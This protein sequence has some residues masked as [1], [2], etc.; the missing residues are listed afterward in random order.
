MDWD[1]INR[2]ACIFANAYYSR[3]QNKPVKYTDERKACSS[4]YQSS[5]S[6]KAN[7]FCSLFSSTQIRILR[8]KGEDYLESFLKKQKFDKESCIEAMRK[9]RQIYKKAKV[10]KYTYGN[11]QKWVNMS[12]KYYYIIKSVYDSN[13][14]DVNRAFVLFPGLQ[15]Y[16]LFPIDSKILDLIYDELGN[17]IP[18]KDGSWYKCDK[19]YVFD[20]IWDSVSYKWKEE[21][22]EMWAWELLSWNP[23]K[24]ALAKP[25]RFVPKQ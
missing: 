9:I 11:A 2:K 5:I 6:E 22:G 1:R 19:I 21:F 15:D 16:S 17:F 20:L 4:A 18:P 3:I 10:K 25:M 13:K 24:K 7:P 23:S 14:I 8:N 12:I